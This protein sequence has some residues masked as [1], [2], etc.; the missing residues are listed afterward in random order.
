MHGVSGTMHVGVTTLYVYM[1]ILQMPIVRWESFACITA[2]S[3]MR[4]CSSNAAL[5]SSGVH[6]AILPGIVLRQ[7]SPVCSWG[8]SI[9]VSLVK[10][11]YMC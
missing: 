7:L 6:S 4:E 5:L 10:A 1:L 9:L 11:M 3:Q 8:L 2:V